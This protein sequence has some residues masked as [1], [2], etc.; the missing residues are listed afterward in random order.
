MG[1]LQTESDTDELLSLLI[2]AAHRP[3]P[4]IIFDTDPK[5]I[6]ERLIEMVIKQK[7]AN[8]LV[9]NNHDGWGATG[10]GAE[11]IL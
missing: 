5:A 3:N 11:V 9:Y 6:V 4:N 8:Q 10:K 7:E 1:I 2:D